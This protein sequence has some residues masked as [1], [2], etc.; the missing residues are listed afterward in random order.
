MKG[1]KG[2]KPDTKL[3]TEAKT[4]LKCGSN[5]GFLERNPN[6]SYSE[7]Y[8]DLENVAYAPVNVLTIALQEYSI[9]Q[10][11]C[12]SSQILHDKHLLVH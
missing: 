4:I 10:C 7:S 5:S 3:A 2:K 1:F 12:D 6:Q 11:M 8:S 9:N